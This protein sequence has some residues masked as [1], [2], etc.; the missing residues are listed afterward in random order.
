MSDEW[1][2]SKLFPYGNG[3]TEDGCHASEA[4][5]LKDYLRKKTTAAEAARAITL[6]MTL[7][8][9]PEESLHRLWGLLQDALVELPAEH[10]E[11]MIE[12]LKAIEELPE[13]DFSGIDEIKLPSKKLWKELPG[14]VNLWCDC[15]QSS[16]WRD[17]A[18]AAK[19]A[20]RD[21]LRLEHVRKAEIEA[22]MAA[23]GIADIPIDWGYEVVGEALESSNAL[24]DF[25][26]PAAEKWFDFCGQ[27]LF[28][29]AEV[30]LESWG[31]KA[32]ITSYRNAALRDLWE[33]RSNGKMNMNRWS[34]WETRL[35]ELQGEEGVVGDAANAALAVN[36][37]MHPSS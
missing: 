33:A 15:F 12:L 7:E 30:G 20:E 37:K 3:N 8:D 17:E 13:P 31:L 14:F 35:R 25:E 19:G 36:D 34:L 18:A 24:L 5:A 1:F 9:E 21:A 32:H 11:P 23:A 22:R 28:R 29:G 27:H 6:Q 26:V 16:V 4:Q 2:T 10:I